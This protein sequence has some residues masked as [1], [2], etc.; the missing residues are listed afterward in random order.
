MSRKNGRKIE[1]FQQSTHH[2][3]HEGKPDNMRK[4]ISKGFTLVPFVTFKMNRRQARQGELR[5]KRG[6]SGGEGA[7]GH[8]VDFLKCGARHG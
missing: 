3:G 1:S 2:K 5:S 8:L 6:S 7:L 4:M